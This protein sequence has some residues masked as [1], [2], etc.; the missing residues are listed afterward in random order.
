MSADPPPTTGASQ[1]CQICAARTRCVVGQLPRSQQALLDPLIH[2][3]S[4]RKGEV[5]QHE[6]VVPLA[7]HAIKLGTVMVSRHGPDGQ[8]YPVAVLGRG[9][10]LGLWGLLDGLTQTGAQALTAARVCELPTSA[11]RN[12]LGSD[13]ALCVVLRQPLL[14]AFAALAD[15]AQV[16]R[17]R[18]LQRQLMA[19]LLLLAQEQ[20]SRTVTLP[21][22]TA[23]AAL[24]CTSR[25]T[26]ARALRLL[27]DNGH[28]QRIDR[29]HA[30]L[31]PDHRAVFA[32]GREPS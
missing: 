23:L 12:A 25:E 13:Q 30:E 24:L 22:Q 7:V 18:T 32:S 29:W 9:H 20:G 31:G 8:P 2:E 15:W 17:Q 21:S 16:T 1:R 14:Q 19:A 28:L 11:L 4:Y 5:L 10:L 6:G 27:E 3:R 26:V